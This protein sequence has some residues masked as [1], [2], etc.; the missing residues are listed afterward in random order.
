MIAS[1]KL[2]EVLLLRENTYPRATRPLTQHR[3]SPLSECL[4]VHCCFP[5]HSL[6][7]LHQQGSFSFKVC[8]FLSSCFGCLMW[9]SFLRWKGQITYSKRG[10]RW[11]DLYVDG[12]ICLQPLHC[13]ASIYF[14][15]T[16]TGGFTFLEDYAL[17]PFYGFYWLSVYPCMYSLVLMLG[18]LEVCMVLLDGVEDHTADA[19]GITTTQP[20]WDTDTHVQRLLWGH[21]E[22]N[23]KNP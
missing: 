17:S 23:P 8:C 16:S 11:T 9:L 14:R 2:S 21:L 19:A 6:C 10:W 4:S 13:A 15:M 3:C 1:F 22:K 5:L 7:L 20:W 12:V 18:A